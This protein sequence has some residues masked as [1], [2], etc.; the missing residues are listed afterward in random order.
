MDSVVLVCLVAIIALIAYMVGYFIGE[1]NEYRL[2]TGPYPK[3]KGVFTVIALVRQ[4][5]LAVALKKDRKHK[6]GLL[7]KIR[8]E[9][10]RLFGECIKEG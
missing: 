10:R 2:W 1:S 6:V 8:R 3:K 4:Y 5:Q 7:K 9:S